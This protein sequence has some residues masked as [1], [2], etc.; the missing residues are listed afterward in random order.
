MKIKILATL[1]MVLSAAYNI[2][3]SILRRRSASNP[4]PENLSDVYDAETYAKWKLYGAEH[5]RLDIFS[6]IC[7]FI[8][9]I[10]LLLVGYR[11][12]LIEWLAA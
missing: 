12:Y 4:T 5:S 8:V 9:N 10:T 1:I 7:A 6:G 11:M 2:T 3:L